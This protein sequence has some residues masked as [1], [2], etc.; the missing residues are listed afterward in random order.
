MMRVV[1]P[2]PTPGYRYPSRDREEPNSECDQPD[3]SKRRHAILISR[4]EEAGEKEKDTE[5]E[6]HDVLSTWVSELVFFGIHAD[7]LLP[8]VRDEPRSPRAR[9]EIRARL[10]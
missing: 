9:T 1:P 8:N 2:L 10:S 6:Q 4:H 5:D 7:R 3:D